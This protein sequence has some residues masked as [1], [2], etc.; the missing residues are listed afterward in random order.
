MCGECELGFHARI[1]SERCKRE[2]TG[3]DPVAQQVREVLDQIDV[4]LDRHSR[5][6]SHFREKKATIASLRDYLDGGGDPNILMMIENLDE[7]D[8]EGGE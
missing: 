5:V 4:L 7:D 6:V 8:D 2:S 1:I 3:R